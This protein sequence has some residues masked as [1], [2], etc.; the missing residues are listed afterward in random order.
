MTEYQ[1]QPHTRR[2]ALTG[3]ELRPG[4][5][6]YTAL[7][8]EGERFLRRDY[9]A[10][11]WQGPPAGAIGF[12]SGRVP[13]PDQARR[14]RIDDD[15][16]MDCFMRL[17]GQDDPSRV[18]FRYVIALLLLRRKWFKF[19]GGHSEGGREVLRMR[20]ARTREVHDV[21]NPGL[22]D[23]E[24]ALVQDEVFKVLGWE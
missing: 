19:E 1:I 24:M 16:L 15:L 4:E 10:E 17:E 6:F 21:V 11:A 20:S 14:P 2:C 18:S 13:P 22:S 8:E 23:E 5:C 9:S 12:W 3:R 7:L